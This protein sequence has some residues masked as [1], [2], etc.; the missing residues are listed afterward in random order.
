MTALM[1]QVPLSY[2]ARLTFA[3]IVSIFLAGCTTNPESSSPTITPTISPDLT[4]TNATPLPTV[5]PSRESTSINWAGY[6]VETSLANPQPGAIDAVEANWNVSATE[7]TGTS[8]DFSASFWIG[9]DG[10]SSQSIVQIGTDS[11]CT[12]GSPQYYCWYE[13]FPQNAVI[14]ALNINPGDEIH[15]RIEYTGNDTFRLMITD[16][17]NGNNFSITVV[18]PDA[19]RNSAEWIVEAPVYRSRILPL[20]DFGPVDFMN[21]SVTVNGITGPISNPGWSYRAIVMEARNGTIK[22]TPTFLSTMG[23]RFRIIWEHP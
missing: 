18:S 13:Q 21:T 23:S 20:S 11:D 10:Y 6:V 17:T 15:A 19:D 9:I 14:I 3:V 1:A 2:L 22:A 16:T 4:Q 5:P 8:G 7:C 12:G